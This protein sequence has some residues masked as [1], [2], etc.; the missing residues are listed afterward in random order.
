MGAP[1]KALHNLFELQRPIIT[2]RS[3]LGSPELLLTNVHKMS[4]SSVALL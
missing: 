1:R 4:D 2:E 3:A